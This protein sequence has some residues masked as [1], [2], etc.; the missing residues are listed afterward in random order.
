MWA[1]S[2]YMGTVRYLLLPNA[3]TY[4]PASHSKSGEEEEGKGV[5]RVRKKGKGK[6]KKERKE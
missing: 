5:R 6:R 4:L 3:L 2:V 1:S